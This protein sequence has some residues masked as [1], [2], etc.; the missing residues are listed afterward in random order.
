MRTKHTYRVYGMDEPNGVVFSEAA[1]LDH[2]AAWRRV[3]RLFREAQDG[4]REAYGNDPEML[5]V[6]MPSLG[7]SFTKTWTECDPER[8]CQ[9][10]C[11]I[12]EHETNIYLVKEQAN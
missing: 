2:R 7:N 11:A 10:W 1:G 3:R 9:S 4:W 6:T 12:V 8:E 5:A